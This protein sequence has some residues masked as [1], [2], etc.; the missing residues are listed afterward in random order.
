MAKVQ[1]IRR[2]NNEPTN[3]GERAID[4]L[5]FIRETM[6]RSAVFTSVPGY[7]GMLMGATAIG[8]AFI[9]NNQDYLRNW[10]IVWVVE[11]VLA[12][13]IGLLAMWQKSKIA[14]TPL[15]SAPAKKFA[16]GFAPPLFCGIAITL[17][18][19]RFELYEAMVAVWLLCYGA[20]VVCG[21]AFSVKIVSI[22]GWCFMLLGA[23]AFLLPKGFGD[24]MM[25]LSFGVLHI[26]FGL[27][28]ARKYGG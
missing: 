1:P 11:A 12:F 2:E 24:E 16:S 4:N 28:I 8:A 9:A 20:A 17:G 22:M 14:K 27:I 10:V 5:Q 6:E 26:V 23:I 3:I 21:G 18:L 7:G 25:A 19:W 15:T 13:S